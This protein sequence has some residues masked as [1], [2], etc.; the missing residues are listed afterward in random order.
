M[1]NVKL[2][3]VLL[4]LIFFFACNDSDRALCE[5]NLE[6]TIQELNRAQSEVARKVDFIERLTGELDLINDAIDSINVGLDEDIDF[7]GDIVEYI[8][9]L[10]SLLVANKERITNLRNQLNE[11]ASG[12]AES[13]LVDKMIASLEVTLAKKEREIIT[14]KEDNGILVDS[15]VLLSE[16][17]IVM[18]E[19]ISSLRLL[20]E[21]L[22]ENINQLR[23]ER[24][25]IANDLANQRAETEKQKSLAL[26]SLAREA[27]GYFDTASEMMANYD[28]IKGLFKAKKKKEYI[29][30]AY[31]N[32]KKA[33]QAG[34]PQAKDRLRILFMNEEYYKNLSIDASIA[35]QKINDCGI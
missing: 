10:D 2:F 7:S 25:Q 33:C 31:E 4:I 9:L 15:I 35:L 29:A 19:E 14:L 17:N 11:K 13:D 5:S 27:Q 26:N 23:D 18:T 20:K 22:I 3:S 6:A 34:H 24:A 1:K 28:D 12:Q 30:I 21:G 32:F 16:E 8:G